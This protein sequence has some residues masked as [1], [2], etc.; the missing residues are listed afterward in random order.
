MRRNGGIGSL[1]AGVA[2]VD[3]T[4]ERGTQLAGDIG[5]YRP[6]EFV[7]D[8]IYAKALVLESNGSKLCF[9]SC[10][11]ASI[12]AEWANK[13]RKLAS[14]KFGL[15]PEAVLIHAVQNHAAP[16]IGH[17]MVSNECNLIPPEL[18]WLRDGDAEYSSFALAR[19]LEAISIANKNS[20]PAWIGAASGVEGR[21][22]FN[23][24]FVMRNGK[25]QTHPRAADPNILYAEGPIDPELGVV[26][27]VTEDARVSAMILYYTCHPTHGYPNRYVTADWPGAWSNGVREVF[28]ETCIPLVVNGCCGNIH[29]MNH[30]DPNYVD[31]QYR[32]GRLLTETAVNV[33]KRISDY[34]ND[35]VLDF[36]ATNIKI[37]LR[38]I[39]RDEFEKARQL[40]RKHPEP[41]WVDDTHTRVDW[42]WMYAVSLLDLYE[43]RQRYP[44]FDYEIQVLRV[45]NIAFV[46]LM[47][48]PFVEG[49]LAIKLQSPTYP[50]Y[51]LHNC[52]GYAGYIPTKHA[53]Q[54]GGYETR[55]SNW[56]KLAPEALDI[57]VNES[58]KMLKEIFTS[59]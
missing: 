5:R 8:P 40:L 54:G 3:I 46:G 58:V 41:L 45:G 36:R 57:I 44:Y 53:F 1:Y 51:V 38:E 4:P 6:N 49:Q 34:R 16:S 56:S 30:L 33:A 9:L 52:N 2:Q 42:D 29:H 22:A 39:S 31:D 48:E 10:D 43:Q 18:P 13:I 35:V 23:R 12:T 50:T 37:P 11:L 32:M 27:I 15:K 26:C 25:V 59:K 47:G 28:G 19:I 7:L 17:I 20:E 14:E 55:T 21:V 24:R